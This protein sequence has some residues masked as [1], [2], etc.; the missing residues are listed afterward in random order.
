LARL[1]N[2]GFGVVV[3]SNQPASAKG[4]TSRENLERVHARIIELV[5]SKGGRI[6]RSYICHHRSEDNC[7]CRK[8][9]TGLLEQAFKD[10]PQFK[11]SQ[12]WMVGDGVGDMQ[13]GQSFGVKTVFLGAF[14]IESERILD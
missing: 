3:V 12:S 4:K 1:T 14:K 5:E 9:A 10:F 8:P 11:V 2:A 6:L 7:Q 13:A